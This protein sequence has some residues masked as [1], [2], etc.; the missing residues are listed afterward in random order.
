MRVVAD[1][2]QVLNRAFSL[3]TRPML[4]SPSF[5]QPCNG[6]S[7]K[8]RPDPLLRDPGGILRPLLRDRR[9]EWP[10]CTECRY[11]PRQNS[12]SRGASGSSASWQVPGGG[13]LGQQ[14]PYRGRAEVSD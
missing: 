6:E 4:L 14:S 2:N 1:T 8:S 11:A 5:Y 12:Q 7:D 9:V 3:D 13:Y 10:E